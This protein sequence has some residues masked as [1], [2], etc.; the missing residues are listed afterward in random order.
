MA[1]PS[2]LAPNTTRNNVFDIDSGDEVNND[3]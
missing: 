3:L 2:R 1:S